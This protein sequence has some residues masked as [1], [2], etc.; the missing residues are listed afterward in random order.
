MRSSIVIDMPVPNFHATSGKV[1]INII[2]NY[3]PALLAQGARA[4]FT[5]ELPLFPL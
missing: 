4:I 1:E 3:C 5:H 2:D